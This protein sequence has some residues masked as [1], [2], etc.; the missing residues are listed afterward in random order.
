MRDS[1]EYRAAVV[2]TYRMAAA[3]V[4][5]EA[6]TRSA[7]TW[8]VILDAD[9]TIISN[10]TYQVERARQGL[11]FSPESWTAWV[12]RR[13]ATPLP[14]AAVPPPAPLPGAAP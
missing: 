13:E 12:R 14:G 7:G 1:A 3:H 5:S 11:G 4:E 9:E 10:V 6:R 8:V 2:Q